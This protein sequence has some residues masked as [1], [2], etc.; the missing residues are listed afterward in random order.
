M[1]VRRAKWLLQ[2]VGIGC[3]FAA[4]I[5]LAWAFFW[6]CTVPT[7]SIVKEG[8]RT[9]DNVP[10]AATSSE[11]RASTL[12]SHWEK[13][14]RAPLIDPP[15]AVTGESTPR[16]GQPQPEPWNATLLGTILE[17]GHNVAII[18]VPPATI[19]VKGV[20]EKVGED[21]F[22]AEIVDVLRDK[23][24][25]RRD[26]A[27]ITLT[28]LPPAVSLHPA[29]EMTKAPDTPGNDIPPAQAGPT[30]PADAAAVNK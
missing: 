18:A 20:G 5:S 4:A 3:Y 9:A 26:G 1:R 15:V 6:P 2:A 28:V 8:R 16:D 30:V 24:V 10:R 27:L 7:L 23:V 19:E 21:P 29:T 17:P 22:G 14:L 25:L 11:S 12:G 13:R